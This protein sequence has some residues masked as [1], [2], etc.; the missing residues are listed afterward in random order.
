[1]VIKAKVM[2]ESMSKI[3]L[4]GFVIILSFGCTR[5]E[6]SVF[7]EEENLGEVYLHRRSQSGVVVLT[8]YQKPDSNGL[9]MLNP[10]RGEELIGVSFN[11]R[12]GL[13]GDYRCYV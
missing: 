7:T 3:L 2:N 8:N 6:E 5:F 12:K 9:R 10:K 11:P 13:V 4:M 1:M